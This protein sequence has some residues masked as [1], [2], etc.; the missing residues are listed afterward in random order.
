MYGVTMMGNVHTYAK[1]MHMEIK[2]LQKQDSGDLTA[3]ID[4]S[5][6]AV[7]SEDQPK[8]IVEAMTV[9]EPTE[10]ERQAELKK[11]SDILQKIQMGKK[12]TEEELKFLKK[13]DPIIY[14]EYTMAEEARK[15]EEKAYKEALKQCKTQEDVQR[16]KRTTMGKRLTRVKEIENNPHIPEEKKALHIGMERRKAEDAKRITDEFVRKGEYDK[17]P[18]EA[19]V[20]EGE[21]AEADEKRAEMGL[22]ENGV[23]VEDKTEEVKPP[24]AAER[25]E[26]AESSEKPEESKREKPEV[27]IETE[28]ERKVRRARARA[29]YAFAAQND[30]DD[31]SGSGQ[32]WMA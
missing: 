20:R 10:E 19:E 32:S 21:K 29:A 11:K 28:A 12:L 31:G 24:E 6:G 4:L 22:D 7:V 8:S 3:K 9:D 13:S 27:D 2:W 30:T 5:T 18:S 25:T 15:Y 26:Q 14:Q 23:P 17:L 1:Q 16:L